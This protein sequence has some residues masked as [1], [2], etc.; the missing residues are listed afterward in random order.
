M[1][2]GM[3]FLRLSKH[4]ESLPLHKETFQGFP[5]RGK[6]SPKVTDEG[7]ICITSSDRPSGGHLPLIGEGFGAVRHMYL[8]IC[9]TC[10]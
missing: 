6:L 7:E 10:L 2:L 8:T 1:P 3:A 9:P 5:L 4:S